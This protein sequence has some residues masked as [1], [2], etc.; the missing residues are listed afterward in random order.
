MSHAVH[1]VIARESDSFDEI[2]Q[3]EDRQWKL[4]IQV[5]RDML[6]LELGQHMR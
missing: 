6:S 5:L 3:W 4:S 2:D 1:D